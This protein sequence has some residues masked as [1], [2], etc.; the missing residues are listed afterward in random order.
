M[1]EDGVENGF[2]AWNLEYIYFFFS[3]EKQNLE[4]VVL[5]FKTEFVFSYTVLLPICALSPLIS[6]S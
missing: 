4:D 3:F 6:L 5:I 2:R 1:M